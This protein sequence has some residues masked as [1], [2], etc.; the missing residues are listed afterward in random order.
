[1]TTHY[2]TVFIST[3][4]ARSC[5]GRSLHITADTG[6]TPAQ[7]YPD[8]WLTSALAVANEDP[9]IAAHC[10]FVDYFPHDEQWAFFSL[11]NPRGQMVNAAAEFA[12]LLQQ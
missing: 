5:P 11:S 12:A 2:E 8:G 4:C 9:Q 1:L 3:G 6:T 10:W 7:N